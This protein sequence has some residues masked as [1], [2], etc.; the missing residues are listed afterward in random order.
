MNIHELMHKIRLRL[1]HRDAPLPDDIIQ[2]LIR[3][4]EEEDRQESCSCDDVFAVLDEYTELELKGQ[5]AARL[6]PLLRKHMDR[7]HD[8]GEEHQALLEILQKTQS[9]P[10]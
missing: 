6:M 7:C 10:S 5:D 3:S 4:L 8:C 2:E 9:I 1:G